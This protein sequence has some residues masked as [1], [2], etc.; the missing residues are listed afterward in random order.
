MLSQHAV[1]DMTYW[2]SKVPAGE[3]AVVGACKLV[4]GVI[5]GV[6]GGAI[7]G[8]LGEMDQ[9]CQRYMFRYDLHNIH[10]YVYV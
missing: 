1:N 6:L 8:V 5:G 3:A 4:G 7:G 9:Y 2:S 10:Q